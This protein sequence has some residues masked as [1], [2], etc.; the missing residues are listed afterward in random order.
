MSSASA[1][2][3]SAQHHAERSLSQLAALVTIGLVAVSGG[4]LTE[5]NRKAPAE[6]APVALVARG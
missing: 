3:A 4:L 2:G 5:M 1:F 6:A